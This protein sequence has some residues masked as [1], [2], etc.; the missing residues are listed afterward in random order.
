MLARQLLDRYGILTREAARAE[1]LPGG[2]ASLYPVLKGME[3]SGRIRR[4]YFVEGMGAAQFAKSGADDR[5]RHPDREARTA[6]L[7]ATDPAN[8]FGASLPWPEG[9]GP[10]R[11]RSAGALVILRNGELSGFLGKGERE[12]AIFGEP[13]DATETAAALA[14][15]ASEPGRRGLLI[16]RINGE[17]APVSPTRRSSRMDSRPRGSA[18]STGPEESLRMRDAR[19]AAPIAAY[20]RFLAKVSRRFA[21]VAAR[22]AES[23]SCRRGCFGCC[24]G[25]FEI[26]AL[27]AAVAA[28]GS[29]GALRGAPGG[30]PAARRGDR[31]PHQ[32]VFPGDP[33]SLSLDVSREDER[34]AFFEG[35]AGIACPF[36]VAD[37]DRAPR[38]AAARVRRSRWPQGFVCA[39]YAHR[40]HAC[41]TFGLPLSDRGRTVSDPCRLNFRGRDEESVR[42]AALPLYE[43]EEE[44]IASAA[45][46]LLGLPRIG[47]VLPAVAAT[48]PR[49]SGLSH[50]R[51]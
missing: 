9:H 29:R 5:L 8:L 28:G 36:L 37:D 24:V 46:S 42:A 40:P 10:R 44:K 49:W 22:E 18:C 7:A 11:E 32:A 47:P 14:A 21:R 16:A 38:T 51:S 1:G 6:V 20:R 15:R 23:V 31:S 50:P 34:D 41:R 2:F 27:D 39:I 13:A 43:P 3:E 30:D 4:G 19:A 45:E 12:L 48:A 26:S 17:D 33:E 25:L 35:T